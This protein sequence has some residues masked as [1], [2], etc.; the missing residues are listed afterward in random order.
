ML[1]NK[2]RPK[3]FCE[4]VHQEKA[5]SHFKK[6]LIDGSLPSAI[7]LT[8]PTGSGKTSVSRILA[9]A[10]HCK[11][12]IDGYEPCGKCDS[13]VDVINEIYQRGTQV[14]DGSQLNVDKMRE[15]DNNVSTTSL[16][17][18]K[19]VIIIEEFQ[20]L[21]NNQKAQKVI[22]PI[23][24]R[25]IPDVHFIILAMDA[26]KVDN[27]ISSR[28]ITYNFESIP[29]EKIAN[30]IKFIAEAEGIRIDSDEKLDTIFTI[31]E[32]C[33]GS[34]RQAISWLETVIGSDSWDSKLLLEATGVASAVLSTSATKD[35][36]NGDSNV[37][38]LP[39]T[40]D[41][42]E[43]I[44]KVLIISLKHKLGGDVPKWEQKFCIKLERITESKNVLDILVNINKYPFVNSDIV[45]LLFIKVLT[46][47]N[48]YNGKVTEQQITTTETDEPKPRRRRRKQVES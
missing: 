25:N 48:S 45:S 33:Y 41:L 1:Y 8:G 13:C 5:I 2:Y 29:F 26:T 32:N 36:L 23:I 6:A 10:I 34:L 20:E 15:L 27:A 35:L 22:L 28:Q 3:Q 14:L 39:M 24:E 46:G 42:V 17:S 47:V 37:F 44:I 31:A 40:K 7:F 12:K 11:S 4:V 21:N 16:V 38:Q 9:M 30:R 43:S 19:K 18:D